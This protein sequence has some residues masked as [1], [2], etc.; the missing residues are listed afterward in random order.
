MAESEQVKKLNE[1]IRTLWARIAALE[2]VLQQPDVD[3]KSRTCCDIPLTLLARQ[4]EAVGKQRWPNSQDHPSIRE[5]FFEAVR[6]SERIAEEQKRTAFKR[7]GNGQEKIESLQQSPGGTQ[8]T[9]SDTHE[10]ND[11]L[12]AER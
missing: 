11:E 1:T 12:S 3:E 2:S 4:L 5:V 10:Q 7:F 6:Q 8:E 9:E